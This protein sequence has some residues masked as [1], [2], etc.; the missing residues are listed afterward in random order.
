MITISG[1]IKVLII[2]ALQGRRLQKLN[3]SKFVASFSILQPTAYNMLVKTIAHTTIATI[4]N[5]EG[6]PIKNGNA[7]ACDNFTVHTVYIPSG[8]TIPQY[9]EL[10]FKEI[11]FIK[12][13]HI[14]NITISGI[15]H[16]PIAQKNK[17]NPL[18]N[19]SNP[20]RNGHFP[21]FQYQRCTCQNRNRISA[22]IYPIRSPKFFCID[23]K[24]Y[25][26]VKN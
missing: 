10:Y 8:N 3:Y 12:C 15:H 7:T 1:L 4:T 14:P 24:K 16:V 25:K 19:G 13:R 5:T 9:C 20:A 22:H 17:V 6:I 18:R 2:F 11:F 26:P 21:A 23:F